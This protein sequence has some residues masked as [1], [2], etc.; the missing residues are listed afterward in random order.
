MSVINKLNAHAIQMKDEIKISAI[1]FM[2]IL[3]KVISGL[4]IGLTIT[5]A[6][7]EIG[8]FGQVSFFFILIMIT[9]LFVKLTK[10]WGFITLLIFD[11]IC[12]LMA[13]LLRIYILVA[14]G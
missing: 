3:L 1:N 11:L 4:V 9:G 5:L 12:V 8:Q 7:Q 13:M 10:S 6:F 2:L 14:P